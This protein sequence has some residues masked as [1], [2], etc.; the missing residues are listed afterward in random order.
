[1]DID[2][3]SPNKLHGPMHYK[4]CDTCVYNEWTCVLYSVVI[5]LPSN[6]PISIHRNTIYQNRTEQNAKCQ[7]PRRNARCLPIH[8]LLNCK[9]GGLDCHFIT[10]EYRTRVQRIYMYHLFCQALVRV[11]YSA[12]SGQCSNTMLLV[13]SNEQCSILT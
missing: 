7:M 1:M 13:N 6:P 10:T 4:I 12:V 8:R 2:Q 3:I 5:R 9:I 11:I